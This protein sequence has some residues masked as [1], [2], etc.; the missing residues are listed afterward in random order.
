MSWIC[1]PTFLSG[2]PFNLTT[3][4][5][6]CINIGICVLKEIVH[7]K[8]KIQSLLTESYE[9]LSVASALV[10]WQCENTR[11]IIPIRRLFFLK[12]KTKV[13]T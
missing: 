10:R 12:N 4:P 9:E 5:G 11:H 2:K 7:C 13:N 1:S 3:R 8:V 6:E